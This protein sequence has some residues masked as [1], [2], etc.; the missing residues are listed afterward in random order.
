[1]FSAFPATNRPRQWPADQRVT[2]DMSVAV[3]PHRDAL[4][5]EGYLTLQGVNLVLASR[6]ARSPETLR[7]AE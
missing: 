7:T 3:E 1:V 4:L 5:R 6:D 2:D